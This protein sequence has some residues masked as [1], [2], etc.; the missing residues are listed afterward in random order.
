MSNQYDDFLRKYCATA[1]VCESRMFTRYVA[2][3]LVTGMTAMESIEYHFKTYEDTILKIEIP[4]HKFNEIVRQDEYVE[5][6]ERTS[7]YNQ[8]IINMLRRDERVR[9][10]NPAVA[11][12]YRNYITLLELARQWPLSI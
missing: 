8:E 9:D 2:P 12:A 11:K 5:H 10:S 7:D 1:S 3:S 4:S 6:L